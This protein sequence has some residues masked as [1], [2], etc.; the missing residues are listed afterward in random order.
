MSFVQ[1]VPTNFYKIAQWFVQVCGSASQSQHWINPRA[2]S[3]HEQNFALDILHCHLW[4]QFFVS[5]TEQLP[6]ISLVWLR[7]GPSPKEG[8]GKDWQRL[9]QRNK[10]WRGKQKL[11]GPSIAIQQSLGS[12]DLTQHSCFGFS[13]GIWG[14]ASI[15]KSSSLV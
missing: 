7:P 13:G 4:S 9:K 3:I 1:R 11:E 10:M 5:S 8:T 14:S 12:S 2:D 6:Q 15:E